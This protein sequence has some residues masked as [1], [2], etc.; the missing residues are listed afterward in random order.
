MSERVVNIPAD[1]LIVDDEAEI[2]AGLQFILETEGLTNT[3]GLSDSRQIESYLVRYRPKVMVLD[4]SMPFIT[5]EDILRLVGTEFPHIPAIVVTGSNQVETAVRCMKNG[6]FDYFT[7]PV[8]EDKF[9]ASVKRALDYTELSEQYASFKEKVLRRELDAPEVFSEIVTD[10]ERMLNLFR[11]LETIA[12]SPAPILMEGETGVGKELFARAIYRLSG[13]EGKFIGVNVAG[14][15]DHLFS[16]TLFGHLKGSF[17]GAQSQ[18]SG[19][20]E[21]A[22]DGILLLD[23]I[24]DLEHVN[25]IKL[26]RLLQEREY[27]PIGSDM[28]KESRIRII[29]STN[30]DL[31]KLSDEGKFRKDLYYRL[32]IHKIEIIPLRERMDD[33]PLLVDHFIGKA[34]T[35]LEKK[36]PTPP[37]ELYNLLATYHFP[38]NIR[39]L[40]S[41]IFDA[42]S[43]HRSKMLSLEHIS[44]YIEENRGR[45]KQQ[46][47]P[48]LPDSSFADTLVL[49]TFEE[50]E[51][52]LIDEAMKR[53]GDNKSAA[54]SMLGI[55]RSG[56]SK[57]IKR[58]KS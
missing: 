26:L 54:A 32:Q 12:G 4:L 36:K 13:C 38:G 56:L 14:L 18:R 24:G 23:E 6:A 39:E 40:E 49:P 42:V 21:E 30:K 17:T 51:R 27:F 33:L 1:A 10:N 34:A 52:A 5:G 48:L 57:K 31:K 35:V 58:M 47:A 50:A 20:V 3:V 53:A 28:P 29:A 8:D 45:S 25:Q 43:R 41:L 7:K 37:H 46:Q 22:E 16:D 44:R 19:L 9:V 11:Y 55:S 15:D 2:V